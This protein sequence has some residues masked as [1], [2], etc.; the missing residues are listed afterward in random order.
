MTVSIC[1][2]QRANT[3]PVHLL[4]RPVRRSP[5]S[6]LL[7]PLISS[8]PRACLPEELRRPGDRRPPLPKHT[9]RPVG[10]SRPSTVT[11]GTTVVLM[12][13]TSARRRARP[14]R[15]SPSSHATL[16]LLSRTP[17]FAP[18]APRAPLAADG[19]PFRD[20]HAHLHRRSTPSH[21]PIPLPSAL[22]TIS[23]NQERPRLSALFPHPA[24]R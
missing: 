14:A 22:K 23:P 9:A 3:T 18:P 7:M 19:R 1:F 16:P 4:M 12:A 2:S 17:P 15:P 24:S 10:R 11:S 5:S 13:L 6:F 20:E 8:A 21:A